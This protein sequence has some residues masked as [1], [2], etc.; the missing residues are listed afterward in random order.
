[1]YEVTKN[2]IIMLDEKMYSCTVYGIIFKFKI[3]LKFIAGLLQY[4][5]S[6][7]VN[8]KIYGTFYGR[9]LEAYAYLKV[10]FKIDQH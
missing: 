6:V 5:S 4:L 7:E 3:C 8:C 1:M 10:I 9:K 2:S